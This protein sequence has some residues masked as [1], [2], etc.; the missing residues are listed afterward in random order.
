MDLQLLDTLS[1]QPHSISF[2]IGWIVVGFSELKL[3]F[4]LRVFVPR[5]IPFG[6]YFIGCY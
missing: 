2:F 6:Y 5:G 1:Q 3:T 4:I